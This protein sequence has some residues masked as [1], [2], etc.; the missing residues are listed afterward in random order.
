MG[1]ADNGAR[2]LV[3]GVGNTLRGDDGIGVAVARALAAEALPE[4]VRVIDGGTEGLNLLFQME[5]ADRVI[6][7]D[8]AEMKKQPG[9]AAV[10][11]GRRVDESAAT[12]SDTHGFG[13]AEVLVLGRTIG[14]D[15]EV[16]IVAIQPEHIGPQDGL[17]ET[18]APR[19]PE[20]VELTKALLA[21]ERETSPEQACGQRE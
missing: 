20:Y 17:S 3:I 14:V 19:V 7:I 10:I 2:V 4:G 5:D 21:T 13:V 9:Q 18:L 6:I 12:F 15:P 1:S 11:D 8:A 16:T